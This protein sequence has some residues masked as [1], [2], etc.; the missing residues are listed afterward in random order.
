MKK[1]RLL[2]P[3]VV[4]LMGASACTGNAGKPECIVEGDLSFDE[5]KTVYLTAR[6]GNPADTCEVDNGRFRFVRPTDTGEPYVAVLQMV[7]AQDS[8]DRLDM[9]VAI[10]NGTVRVGIGEYIQLSGTPLN[11]RIKEFLD[12]LQHCKDGLGSKPGTT[13]EEIRGIFSEFYRQQILSNKDNAVGEYIYR[14][15]GVHLN[16]DDSALVKAQMGN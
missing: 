10:E 8:T 9:P 15:Y 7:A 12:A 13:V 1:Y 11:K 4:L 3:F 5:Y 6:Q 2:L 14:N 16:A